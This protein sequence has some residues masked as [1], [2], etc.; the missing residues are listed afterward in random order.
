MPQAYQV[1]LCTCP[2]FESAE[3]LAN[4]IISEKSAAC[5]NILPGLTSIYPWQGKIETAKEHLLLIKTR[6]DH[7][8]EVERNIRSNHPYELPE[9]IAVPVEQGQSEYLQW[10]DSCLSSK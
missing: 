2:D 1:I 3:K 7:F 4:I 10:I 6:A 5:V 9:I 8:H